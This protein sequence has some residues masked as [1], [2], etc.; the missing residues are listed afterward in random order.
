M[1]Y[2]AFQLAR[3]PKVP[4]PVGHLCPRVGHVHWTHL[5]QHS[6]LH[7]N[8]FSHFCTAHDRESLYFSMCVK[9]WL[10]HG[11]KK[12]VAMITTTTVLR[13]F[14][15]DHPCEPVPE[16]N[17]WTLWCK[18]RLMEADTPT[19]RLGATP[20]GLISA[21]LQHLPVYFTGRMPFLPPSQQRQST[22]G[23]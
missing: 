18:G 8:C 16:G 15:P 7:L 1:L 21:C 13:P 11:Q 19:T 17:F 4:L 20:S 3:H 12:S 23:N 9:T 10:T 2:N 6:T 14:F 5:T 22:E